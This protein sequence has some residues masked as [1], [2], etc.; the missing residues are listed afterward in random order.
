MKCN[1][2]LE[3]DIIKNY[4]KLCRNINKCMDLHSNSTKLIDRNYKVN[5]V[6]GFEKF[7]EIMK[8][9]A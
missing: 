2:L 9:E 6:K 3:T 8:E 4:K 5:N 1:P 7:I